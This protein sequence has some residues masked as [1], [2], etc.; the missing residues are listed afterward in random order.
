[1]NWLHWPVFFICSIAFSF[2]IYAD[3]STG[4]IIKV[5][6]S[7]EC[8]IYAMY[9]AAKSVD[10]DIE[11]ESFFSGNFVSSANGSS[12]ADLINLA[13]THQI[14]AEPLQGISVAYLRNSKHPVL[15]NIKMDKRDQCPG[16]WITF[17][18]VENGKAVVF[19]NLHENSF[20]EIGLGQLSLLMSGYGIV[21]S[22]E[23]RSFLEKLNLNVGLF[24]Y[25]TPC[26]AVFLTTLLL[27][28]KQ[29]RNY[30]HFR[31]LQELTILFLIS[32]CCAIFHWLVSD[33]GFRKN[34]GAVAWLESKHIDVDFPTIS[35][36][37]LQQVRSDANVVLVDARPKSLFEFGHIPNAVNIS[38][39][40][41]PDEFDEVMQ[42]FP[43]DKTAIV[44]CA[45]DACDWDDI[46]ARRLKAYGH[47]R[48]RVYQEGIT[49]FVEKLREQHS[50]D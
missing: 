48:I 17:L 38:V 16:H 47:K 23:Q 41:S 22:R 19:D 42:Q 29:I 46:V 8:G 44:Y 35:F 39:M 12:V 20:R 9:A 14:Y 2:C 33:E 13:K 1:M 31:F 11:I 40:L 32:I 27:P 34:R 7:A 15:L 18:G 5:N 25:L 24:Y 49:K 37:Q 30:A 36:N 4:P 50:F 3:E 26:I 45:T 10:F 28:R 43:R 21:V 6:N